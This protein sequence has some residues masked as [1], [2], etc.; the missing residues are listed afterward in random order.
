MVGIELEPGEGA[1]ELVAK[2]EAV[3]F[4][5]RIVTVINA[6]PRDLAVVIKQIGEQEGRAAGTP[7]AE[8]APAENEGADDAAAAEAATEVPS[9]EGADDAAAAEAAATPDTATEAG[10]ESAAN[11]PDDAAAGE[12]PAA[13]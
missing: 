6:V 10:S 1:G 5:E 13:E 11:A 7:K 12:T 3:A 9:S 8:A 4:K 2:A